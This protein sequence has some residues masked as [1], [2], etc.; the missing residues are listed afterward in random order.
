M[1]QGRQLPQEVE[2]T[3]IYHAVIVVQQCRA[4]GYNV[5]HTVRDKSHCVR[6]KKVNE[7]CHISASCRFSISQNY[8]LSVQITCNEGLAK[9]P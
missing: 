4:V 3:H 7:I 5:G 2:E 6:R 9:S 1:P 8:P